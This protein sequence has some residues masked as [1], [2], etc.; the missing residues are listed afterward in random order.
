MPEIY[1]RF[2]VFLC[3]KK[4]PRTSQGGQLKSMDYLFSSEMIFC[5]RTTITMDNI[6][7][8]NDDMMR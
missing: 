6:S 2:R 4:P 5:T 8:M 7:A 1:I 3:I